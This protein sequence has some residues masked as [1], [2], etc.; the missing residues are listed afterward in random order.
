[1][2]KTKE[3]IEKFRNTNEEWTENTPFYKKKYYE[4]GEIFTKLKKVT[5]VVV[6]LSDKG[7]D[8]LF[9][10][11]VSISHIFRGTA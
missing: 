4:L 1:M 2:L 10:T 3:D 6:F 5:R 7:K 8:L 9:R 11:A